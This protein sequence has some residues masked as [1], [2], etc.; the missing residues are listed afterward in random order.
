MGV[1][2]LSKFWDHHGLTV[3]GAMLILAGVAIAIGVLVAVATRTSCHAL[4]TQ[5]S[6][7]VKWDFWG[8]CFVQTDRGWIPE[9]RWRFTEE[10]DL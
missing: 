10:G 7:D 4:G 9:D 1:G 6:R 3:L 5:V 8:G 2:P